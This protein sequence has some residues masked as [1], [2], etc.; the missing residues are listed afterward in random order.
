MR[1]TRNPGG[2]N[3]IECIYQEPTFTQPEKDFIVSLGGTVVES[4]DGYKFIDGS[5]LVFGVH[6]YQPVW[7]AAL[8][9]SLPGLFVGTSLATWEE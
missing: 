7:E 1:L 8:E 5:T 3:S 6:L 9:K 4:P 2:E